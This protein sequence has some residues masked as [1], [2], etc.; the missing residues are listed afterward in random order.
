MGVTQQWIERFERCTFRKKKGEEIS[1]KDK[2]EEVQ[3][4]AAEF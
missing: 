4:K 2:G 1:S 3:R